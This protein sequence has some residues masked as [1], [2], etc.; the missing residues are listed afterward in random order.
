M[1]PRYIY[2]GDKMTLQS[3]ILADNPIGYWKLDETSGGT[4]VDTAGGFGNGTYTNGPLLGQAYLGY[5]NTNSKSVDFD[6]TN[7][8]V[9]RASSGEL[10]FYRRSLDKCR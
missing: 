6:G 5:N 8:H 10:K 7:D 2:L 4:A 3:E 9:V 1:G